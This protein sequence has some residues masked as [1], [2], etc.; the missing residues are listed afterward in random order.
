RR[1]DLR[2]AQIKRKSNRRERAGS[3]PEAAP[4]L[5]V[6]GSLM[7]I[8]RSG[9]SWRPYRTAAATVALLLGVCTACDGCGGPAGSAEPK[10]AGTPSLPADGTMLL[11]PDAY[12]PDQAQQDLVRRATDA[13][14]RDCMHRLG[15]TSW[16][17]RAEPTPPPAGRRYSFGFVDE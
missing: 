10:L 7:S 13:A 14:I 11:P 6:G 4:R 3:L 5:L 8:R 1:L 17:P 12:V 16:E 15:F 2:S 9:R